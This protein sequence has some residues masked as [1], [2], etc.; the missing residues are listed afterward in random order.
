MPTDVV[1]RFEEG[2]L[3]IGSTDYSSQLKEIS[4][5]GG[6]APIEIV[7]T[8]GNYQYVNAQ[9][10]APIEIE[11]TTHK[12]DTDM[13]KLQFGGKA[14]ATTGSVYEVVPRAKTSLTFTYTDTQVAAGEQLKL[15]ALSAWP[16]GRTGVKGNV[17]D[18]LEETTRWIVPT[19]YY[20]ERYTTNRTASPLT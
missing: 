15:E 13:A 6:D 9:P 2:S 1:W 18:P 20:R 5:G 10:M 8:M 7:R 4:I 11:L 19:K 3:V 17:N 12:L 16:A 14:V